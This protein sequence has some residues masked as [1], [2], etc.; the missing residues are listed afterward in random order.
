MKNITKKIPF[1]W[2]V[3]CGIAT[4]LS[5]GFLIW[6]NSHAIIIVLSFLCVSLFVLLV[7]LLRAINSYLKSSRD[8]DHIRIYTDVKYETTDGYHIDYCN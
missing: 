5:L 2:N 1:L 4:L 8:S 3:I 6:G 7:V